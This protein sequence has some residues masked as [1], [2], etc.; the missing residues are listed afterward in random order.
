MRQGI[1]AW[2]ATGAE[3]TRPYFPA[4]LAAVYP[5]KGQA[6][7]GLPLLAEALV[8]VHNTGER[9]YEA[10]LYRLQGELLLVQAGNRQ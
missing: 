3:A 8:A 6:E 4:L 7:A 2:Q 1:A 9:L 10:E 5:N